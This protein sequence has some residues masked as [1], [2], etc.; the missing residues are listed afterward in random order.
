MQDDR[1]I[2]VVEPID[3]PIAG[4]RY[5]LISAVAAGGMGR[6]WRAHDEILDRDVAV[7]EVLAPAGFPTSDANEVL[8]ATVQEAR[9]AA[10][11]DHPN[12]VRIFD[13]VHEVGRSWIVMEY[14]ASRSLQDAIV[15]DGPLTHR[16]AARVGLAVL[17]ALSA[18]HLAGVLHRDVK[19]HNVLIRHDG[20]V[21]LTDFG[22]ASI[23]AAAD[24]SEPLLGSPHYLAPERLR[25]GSSSEH[26][27]L[28]SLGATLYAAVEGQPP[29]ARRTVAESLSALLTD[30]PD[31]PRHPG[32]LHEVIGGL[33]TTDP[34]YRLSAT[35]A[36]ILLQDLL[37]RAVGIYPVPTPRR[38]DDDAVR[39]RPATAAVPTPSPETVVAPTFDHK[40]AGSPA[41]PDR[42][43]KLRVAALI[44]AVGVAAAGGTSAA[45][46]HVGEGPAAQRPS[47]VA[48]GPVMSLCDGAHPYSLDSGITE[49]PV[50]VPEGWLWHVDS[51]GFALLVPQGWGRRANDPDVCFSDPGDVR[52]F[53]VRPG[54]PA[55]GQPL[56]RW[57]DTEQEALAADALPG[58]QRIS[59]G[60]LLVAGGG[61]DWEYTW[62]PAF[63]PR[64]HTRRILVAAGENRSYSLSWTTRD[65]DWSLDLTN[66]RIIIDGFRGSLEPSA[67]WAVP[68]PLG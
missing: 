21:V 1:S 26:S 58:Y 38:P 46:G 54:A 67:T 51:A 57:Q 3:S 23:T 56:Q 35:D 64:I 30:A 34:M 50:S 25:D 16:A 10:R 24:Q 29:F 18:A 28:W 14:V 6:V 19:P 8:R 68:A 59:M 33:L 32:P 31:P 20:R 61:A 53:T 45:W 39:F 13:V 49:S 36:R 47:A 62:Q 9:A 42:R 60:P 15:C 27:D 55:G 52:S 41:G 37:Q 63:G 40:T 22:L 11:L 5:R 43:R 7:K 4:G 48:A 2:G 66:Q 12:V 17:E 65:T 44:V